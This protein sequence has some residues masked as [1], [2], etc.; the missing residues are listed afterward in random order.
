MEKHIL[1]ELYDILLSR[2]GADPKSSHTAK[3]YAKGTA[4]IAQKL[5]EEAVETVIEGV[6]GDL[7]KLTSESA[8]LLY[9]LVLLWAACGLRPEAVWEELAMRRGER[10]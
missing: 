5:G 7:A 2:R 8:D 6:K 1:D 9:F 3:M 4:K 10:R